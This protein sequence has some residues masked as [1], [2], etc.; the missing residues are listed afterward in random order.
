MIKVCRF[1]RRGG[2]PSV[3]W[4]LRTGRVGSPMRSERMERGRRREAHDGLKAVKNSL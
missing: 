2:V 3:G 4:K 1:G